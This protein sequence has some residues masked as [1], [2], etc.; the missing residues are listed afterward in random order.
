METGSGAATGRRRL[1]RP[2]AGNLDVVP[3]GSAPPPSRVA[4]PSRYRVASGAGIRLA[5]LDPDE[6]EGYGG[7][8]DVR[9]ELAAHRDRIAELQARL[10]AEQRRSLLIVLQALTRAART[11]RSRASSAG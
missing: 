11:G 10:F 5:E 2:S 6:T 1:P 8:G 7:K 9:D 4:G 3:D